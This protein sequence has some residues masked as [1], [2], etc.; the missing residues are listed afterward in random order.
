[1]SEHSAISM[2]RAAH[3][4]RAVAG[5]YLYAVTRKT[6]LQYPGAGIGGADV[7]AINQGQLSAVVSDVF[8]PKVRPER[9]HLTA[10][11]DVLARLMADTSLLPIAFGTIADNTPAIRKALAH[12][13]Q[14]LLAQLCR[15][16][17]KVEMGLRVVW[18]VPNIFEYFINTHPKLR[19]ARDRFFGGEREPTHEE[20]I[21]IGRMFDGLLQDER[22]AC[23]QSVE[24][25][26]S[27][28]CAEV[29][30]CPCRTEREVANI[31]CLVQREERAEFETHVLAAASLF[32]SN[33]AFDY[34]G[35]WPPYNF[36]DLALT[37]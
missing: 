13:Q 10:H 24:E 2:K 19:A 5:K 35:P 20:K 25:V 28:F 36:V 23:A 22:E 3:T 33:Y 18:D 30:C 31:A 34:S 17:G 14:D 12:H 29:K 6:E 8:C 26:I 21:E 15:V 32:D 7:V 9:R 4:P 1:M 16:E 37:L 27:P 11:R